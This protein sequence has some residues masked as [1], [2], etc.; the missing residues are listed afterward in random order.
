MPHPSGDYRPL[1]KGRAWKF[2]KGWQGQAR[3]GGQVRYA[4]T[5]DDR[6]T[7]ATQGRK[8][9]LAGPIV[10]IMTGGPAKDPN[11][12]FPTM[13]FEDYRTTCRRRGVQVGTIEALLIQLCR[14]HELTL[15][16]AD[17]DFAAAAKHVTFRLRKPG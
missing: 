7:T 1:S 17:R 4:A 14:R 13:G 12:E 10:A 2:G 16:S 6:Y 15:L 3:Q 9:A 8:A 11:V 5:I